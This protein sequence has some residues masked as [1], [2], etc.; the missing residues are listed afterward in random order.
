MDLLHPRRAYHRAYTD[1]F[2][3]GNDDIIELSSIRSLRNAKSDYTINSSYN[4]SKKGNYSELSLTEYGNDFHLR[5]ADTD[6]VPLMRPSARERWFSGWRMGAYCAA[7]LALISLII[8]MAA[9]IWLRRHPNA[10]SNLVEVFN[11]DCNEV[12]KMDMWIHLLINAISTLLLGGSNYCMQCLCAP[13]RAEIDKAHEKGRY[14][15]VGVPSYRNLS[16]IAWPR[17]IMWWTLGLS[18]IPLHLMYNSAFYSSLSS[19]DYEIY[20]VIPEFLNA[21]NATWKGYPVPEVLPSV[22]QSEI[23][24]DKNK[25]WIRLTPLECIQAY[26]QVFLSNRRNLVLVTSNA[27]AL[28]AN[29]STTVFGYHNYNF[30]VAVANTNNIYEPFDWLCTSD[31]HMV[32]KI[33]TPPYINQRPP[34]CDSYVSQIEVFAGTWAPFGQPL[35]YCL[36]ESIKE[37]CSFNGNLPIVTTVLIANAIKAVIML[38]VAYHLQGSPLITLG[39][40]IESFLDVPDETTKEVCF[41]T[42]DQA[43]LYNFVNPYR[44]LSPKIHR[45]KGVPKIDEQFRERS[46]KPLR[47]SNAASGRRWFWT[48]GLLIGALCMVIGFMVP[49]MIA[50]GNNGGDWRKLGFGTVHASALVTGWSLDDIKDPSQQILAAI[51]IANLPQAILSFLYLNLNGLLTSMWVANEWSRF[52]KERKPLRVSTPKVGQRS[53]HFLGLPY[54]IA[55]PLMIVSG[56]LHWLVS[57]SIFLAVVAE[58]GPRTGQ[59]INAVAIST[60]GFSPLAQIIVLLLGTGLIVVSIFI[61]RRKYDSSMPLAGS[62]SAAISAACHRPDWDYRAGVSSVAWGI[63]PE[64]DTKGEIAH[65]CFTSGDVKPVEEGRQYAGLAARSVKHK[66]QIG[67]T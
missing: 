35:D 26:S 4:D 36:S 30:S 13:T 60:C 29:S 31:P 5:G 14:L 57:Q 18:S 10:T 12:S 25:T 55:M 3:N 44:E 59:L 61:G 42:R 40:A 67:K 32:D 58:Y 9:A 6:Q 15:D 37:Q 49:G 8:N 54:K 2:S 63:L 24:N 1:D 46:L 65:C 41:L 34:P 16:S 62:C 39:D 56:L 43:A 19:V 52:A 38:V 64:T 21:T 48:I 17:V 7:C 51:L 47:W 27:S 28:P 33:D 53:T 66:W 45:W 11:G 23:A 50:V 22:I 20:S